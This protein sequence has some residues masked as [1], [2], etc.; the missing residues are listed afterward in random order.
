MTDDPFR[1]PR[2]Y[3]ERRSL[4]PAQVAALIFG[5]L[6]VLRMLGLT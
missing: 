1:P 3:R 6:I 4:T 5:G 2:E